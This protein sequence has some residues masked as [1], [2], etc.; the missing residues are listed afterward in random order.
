MAEESL[1]GGR[2]LSDR[3]GERPSKGRCPAE[4]LFVNKE[5]LVGNVVAEGHLEPGSH[6]MTQVF[7]SLSRKGFSKTP[8]PV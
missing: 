8:W 5:G 1:E 7:D 2:E 3:A 6:E 4:L